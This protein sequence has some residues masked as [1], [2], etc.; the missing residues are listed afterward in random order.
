MFL[1]GGSIQK[2]RKEVIICPDVTATPEVTARS[3]TVADS[4][5]AVR[6]T[7][8]SRRK[9]PSIP[10]THAAKILHR[11]QAKQKVRD[12]QEQ[13]AVYR[14][15]KPRV[16]DTQYDVETHPGNRGPARPLLPRRI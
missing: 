15:F 2:C 10:G 11:L 13:K 4:L 9:R 7:P 3:C 6:Q 16:K 12:R 8:R 5:M 1:P 14:Q